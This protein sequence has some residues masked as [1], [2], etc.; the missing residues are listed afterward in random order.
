VIDVVIP[1]HPKD[2]P[3]LRHCVRGVLR[4]I[5]PL[6][7]VFVVSPEPYTV[8]NDRVTWVPEPQ[9]GLPSLKEIEQDWASRS[10][11][12]TSR[13]A[14]IYQ[15]LLKLGAG[16]YIEKLAKRFLVVDADVIFLR[17]VSFAD[18]EGRI[19]YSRASEYNPPYL[20]AYRRLTG[21][22]PPSRESLTAH[23]MLFDQELLG[24]LFSAI[25]RLHSEPWYWAYIHAADPAEPSAINEQ[26]TFGLWLLGHHPDLI[27]HR[28]L[29]WRDVSIIP[30][31]LG[32]AH[33]GLDYDFVAVH[34]YRR[35]PKLRRALDLGLRLAREIA[36]ARRARS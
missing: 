18:E 5:A 3:L 10:P 6:R 15:Q 30:T 21:E 16:T 9:A 32:R 17:Y 24:E 11:N 34:A 29:F 20:D 33:L 2:Y 35:G 28:Q 19:P 26:D 14:W 23:H 27:R 7:Q 25:E 1:A 8:R 22:E 12:A 13:A 31:A 4:H 36:P